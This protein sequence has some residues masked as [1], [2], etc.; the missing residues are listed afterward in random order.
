MK[1]WQRKRLVRI[2]GLVILAGLLL[3]WVV[4]NFKTAMSAMTAMIALFW[5]LGMVLTSPHHHP[6]R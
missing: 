1:N 6:R 5:G 4:W 2:G 3:V